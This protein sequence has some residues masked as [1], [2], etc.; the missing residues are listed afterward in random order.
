MNG[1]VKAVFTI[2][3]AKALQYFL[4]GKDRPRSLQPECEHALVERVGDKTY[5]FATD[6]VSL[7]IFEISGNVEQGERIFIN[8]SRLDEVLSSKTKLIHVVELEDGTLRLEDLATNTVSQPLEKPQPRSNRNFIPVASWRSVLKFGGQNNQAQSSN[9]NV[10]PRF[11]A[12]ALRL[13]K[14]LEESVSETMCWER[15]RP[16][17]SFARLIG[18]KNFAL[19]VGENK[20][21]P[22]EACGVYD[23][24]EAEAIEAAGI[25]KLQKSA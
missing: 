2:K 8:R 5:V 23:E 25:R 10:S 14:I 4:S 21:K 9:P 20:W 11:G 16:E 15:V 7:L 3:Q 22:R 6:T 19:Y 24:L 1:K 17:P 12:V 18:T 13:A